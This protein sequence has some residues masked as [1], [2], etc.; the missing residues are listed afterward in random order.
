[1]EAFVRPGQDFHVE[2]L[3]PGIVIA[4]ERPRVLVAGNRKEQ[5]VA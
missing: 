3:L 5:L 4:R 1:M 2:R